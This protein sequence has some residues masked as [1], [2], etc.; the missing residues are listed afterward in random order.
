MMK[1]NLI[2]LSNDNVFSLYDDNKY[3][4]VGTARGLN[5]LDKKNEN[6]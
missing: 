3:L 4:W 2:Q 6:I 1:I 5:R